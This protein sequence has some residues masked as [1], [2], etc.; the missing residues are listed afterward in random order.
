MRL[1]SHIGFSILCS[2]ASTASVMAQPS[3]GKA[4]Y[5]CT[6]AV[7]K[8][9]TADRPITECADREQRV[10]GPTGVERG[11]VGPALTEVEMA[12]HLEQRRQEQQAQQRAQEQ[13]RRD[14]A[15][16]ARYPQRSNHEA[17]RRNALVQ[18][19]ELKSLAQQQMQV[20][21]KERQQLQQE[22]AFYAQDPA[23]TPARLRAAVQTVEK[24]QR[25]QHAT[26]ASQDAEVQRIH[27]RFDEELARLQPLWASQ[28]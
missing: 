6:D 19:E 27:Q 18:I 7:G 4:I 21:D 25:D 8:R 11:R 23:K 9:L 10:L 5:T 15:L 24:A 20:L 3:P 17:A 14:A 2:I 16:L 13:R 28:P 26:L 22:Q 1:A 12:Q